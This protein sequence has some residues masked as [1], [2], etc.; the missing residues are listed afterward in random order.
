MNPM[1][2]WPD[3]DEDGLDDE[4]ENAL[5]LQVRPLLVFDLNENALNEDEPFALFQ[6]R[7]VALKDSKNLSLRIRWVLLFAENGGYWPCSA[8]CDGSHEGD[9]KVITYEMSSKDGGITWE[10]GSIALGDNSEFVWKK[11]SDIQ[12]RSG[13][14]IIYMSSGRHNPYFATYP[15]GLSSPYSTWGCCDMVNGRGRAILPEISNIGEIKAHPESSFFHDLAPHFKGRLVW[16][17]EYFFTRKAGR[18]SDKW[19]DNS[20]TP[21]DPALVSIESFAEPGKF[22]RHKRFAGDVSAIVSARDRLG[23]RF[24]MRIAKPGGDVVMFE[25]VNYPGYFLADKDSLIILLKP[26]TEELKKSAMFKKVKG[27]ASKKMVSFKSLSAPDKYLRVKEGHLRV[28]SGKG[29]SFRKDATF[30]IA[31][32]M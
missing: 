21:Y 2:V 30:R 22:I 4:M 8:F 9:I 15:E 5:A 20:I 18:I 3:M 16:T 17:K 26:G 23:S 31:V 7:P 25:S 19:L 13:S 27:L 24:Y 29:K 11:G 12:Y 28:E 10:T 1:L 32:P 14:P 6:V